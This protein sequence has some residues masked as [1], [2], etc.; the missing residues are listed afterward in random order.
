MS[1][2]IV[3][4]GPE[5]LVLA[6]DSRV[7]LMAKK[8][9]Q[10]I[11]VNFDNA[12]KLLTFK[13]QDFIGAVTYGAAVIGSRTAHS[14]LPEFEVE[15]EKYERLKT[16]EFANNLSSFFLKRWNENMPK[17]YKDYNMTFVVG[18]YDQ[19]EAYGRVYLFAIP[20]RP[21]PQPR[22]VGEKDFGMTWGGQLELVSRMIHGFDPS[23][24]EILRQTLNLSPEQVQ[25]V[26]QNLSGLEFPIPYGILP[27]QDCIN[28][29]ISMIR[30]TITFQDLA[31]VVRGVG[32]PIE[33]TVITRTKGLE[34][35]QKKELHGELS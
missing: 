33:V 26:K 18:G 20:E 5:G 1:L 31:G 29:A 19:G 10:V 9:D 12:T 16:E 17:D 7:T 27:L 6:A 23:L 25:I 3:I 34:Y 30:S 2:G 21:E 24:P 4:K 35:I 8:S 11:T 28:L 22:N 15:L 32:G 13:N 14:F